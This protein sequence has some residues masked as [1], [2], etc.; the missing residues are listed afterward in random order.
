MSAPEAISPTAHYTGYVWARNGLSHP[1]LSSREGRL[2]F[3][4]FRPLQIAARIAGA[5]SLES[6]LLARHDAIDA[7][8]RRAI[9]EHG[10]T[11]VLEV[12]CGL[13]PRG[14]GFCERY[15]ERITYIEADLP[16]MAERKRAALRRMGSLSERHRVVDLDALVDEGPLSL[17]AVARQ[18]NAVG[19]LVIITEGL[20][21]YLSTDTVNGVWRRFATVLSGFSSGHYVSDLHIGGEQSIHVRWFALLLSAFV[22]GRV[23]LHYGSS[24][25]ATASLEAAGFRSAHIDRA[26]ELAPAIRGPGSELVHIIE[27]SIR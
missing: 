14:W 6:Y 1:E 5:P 13:S 17:A 26:S 4:T 23:S 22:R 16:A 25:D 15:G 20:L 10:V 2:L 8:V 12:A 24:A 3:E 7:L 18:L 11:Q 21:G 19:G 9:E 27:A